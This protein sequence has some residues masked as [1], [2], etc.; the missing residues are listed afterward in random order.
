[1]T[2]NHVV[3]GADKIEVTL[4]DGQVR[5]ATLIGTDPKSNTKIYHGTISRN[6][7]KFTNQKHALV[8]VIT[9]PETLA[10]SPNCEIYSITQGRSNDRPKRRKSQRHQENS[11]NQNRAHIKC[12]SVLYPTLTD[13]V[14]E[15]QPISYSL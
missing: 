7:S 2:N 4:N 3:R 15:F 6:I 13:A 8:T 12:H 1:M 14:S 11:W 9:S 10:T 5:T